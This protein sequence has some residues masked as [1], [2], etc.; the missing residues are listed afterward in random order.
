M[1]HVD[2]RFVHKLLRQQRK[3]IML[4]AISP[5]DYDALTREIIKRELKPDSTC[6]DVGCHSGEILDMMLDLAPAGEFFCFEPIPDLASRLREKYR[7]Q[8]V[9]IHEL[10]LSERSGQAEFN[11]VLS[12]PGYSGLIKRRY[13]RPD[14]VDK[15]ITVNTDTLDNVLRGKNIDFMKIDVEGAELQVLRGAAS[16]LANAKPLIVFEHGFG[17]ADCYGTTPD[18]IWSFLVADLHYSIYCLH[19]WLQDGRALKLDQFNSHYQSGAHY[20]FLARYG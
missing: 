1:E 4:D 18:M 17:A 5:I 2:Q 15:S 8:N 13:D 20:Y 11:Y 12:N 6:V 10:A 16:T 14:E 7:L 9:H 19:D 3:L